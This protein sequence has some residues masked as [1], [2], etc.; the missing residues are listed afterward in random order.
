[1]NN[2]VKVDDN[3]KKVNKVFDC[4]GK[5]LLEKTNKPG[6][7]ATKLQQQRQTQIFDYLIGRI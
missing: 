4:V 6:Q 3:R 5:F 7:M 2:S 1:M